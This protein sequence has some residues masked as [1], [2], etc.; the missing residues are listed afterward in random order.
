M[1][2][3]LAFDSS[4]LKVQ[5]SGTAVRLLSYLLQGI[6]VQNHFHIFRVILGLSVY[7]YTPNQVQTV[8]LFFENMYT[9]WTD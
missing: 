6:C 4:G 8:A 1:T 5:P 9:Y 2:L 3:L 7:T